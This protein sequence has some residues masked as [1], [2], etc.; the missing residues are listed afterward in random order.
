MA[1]GMG[2]R[3][4]LDALEL[5]TQQHAE[6]ESLIDQ[7][8]DEGLPETDKMDLF[9]EL[10]DK[11]AAYAAVEETLFYPAV[12]AKLIEPDFAVENFAIRRV[13]SDMLGTELDDPRFEVRLN[14]LEEEFVHHAC[15]REEADLFPTLRRVMSVEERLALG[16]AMRELYDQLLT[17]RPRD[18]R[19]IEEP[20]PL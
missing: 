14:V 15:E 18:V 7:L 11:L 13:L 10:A 6:V 2:A 17:Q 1:W 8:H 5:L 16:D 12:R 9:L 19:S 3:D 20:A 4:R